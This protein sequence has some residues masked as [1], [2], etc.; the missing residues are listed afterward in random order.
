MSVRDFATLRTVSTTSL[1]AELLERLASTPEP[2]WNAVGEFLRSSFEA[3]H[4]VISL[5]LAPGAHEL[6]G[7][8]GLSTEWAARY[9]ERFS[10]LNPYVTEARRRRPQ[11]GDPLVATGDQLVPFQRAREM[12]F[13]REFCA[14]LNVNDSLGA[15]LFDGQ[16][17]LGHVSLRRAS[18]RIRY[19]EAEVAR[20]RS[21]CDVLSASLKRSRMLR[22]LKARNVAFDRLATTEGQGF[23]LFDHRGVVL[24]FAGAG[25][26]VVEN[27]RE[28]LHSAVAA[29]LEDPTRATGNFSTFPSE[30]LKERAAAGETLPADFSFEMRRVPIEGRSRVLCILTTRTLA[31]PTSVSLP[32][33]V[34]FTPREREVLALLAKG[35]D[36][37][38]IA[39]SLKIGLYTTKDHVKAIFR[40]LGVHTRAEAVAMLA[41]GAGR[42]GANGAQAPTPAPAN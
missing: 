27:D 2:N 29:Y 24:D 28:R 32:T 16:R 12:T 36:N 13:Y 34:H 33:D 25:I 21:V 35:L 17:P 4:C 26:G 30:E 11:G 42:N 39:K 38:S 5:W 37:M 3:D 20:L 10:D 6:L 40:K 15:M 41:R 22:E 14:P 1:R 8:A 23:V 31:T 7:S 19:G 9:E 18:G